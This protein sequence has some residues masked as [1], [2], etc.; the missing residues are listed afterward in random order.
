MKNGEKQQHYIPAA[1]CL[2]SFTQINFIASNLMTINKERIKFFN[3]H[4]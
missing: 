2:V 1:H 3:N 4:T